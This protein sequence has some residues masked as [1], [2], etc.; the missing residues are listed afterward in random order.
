M[1]FFYTIM[2]LILLTSCNRKEEKIITYINEKST[3]I[4]NTNE[5]ER[6]L[7]EGTL[8]YLIEFQKDVESIENRNYDYYIIADGTLVDTRISQNIAAIILNRLIAM[9]EGDFSAFR[10][11]FDGYDMQDGVGMNQYLHF[12][13]KWFGDILEVSYDP[14]ADYTDEIR[15]KIAYDEFT[16]SKRYMWKTIEKIEVVVRENDPDGKHF[17]ISVDILN[18][19]GELLNYI[20]GN[21]FLPNSLGGTGGFQR[22]RDI[23]SYFGYNDF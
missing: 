2:L 23:N 13:I 19:E 14:Q 7:P 8:Q 16:P 4:Y 18:Y 17:L 11:T 9:E 10:A 12:V 3:E 22:M 1:K 21:M 15:N 5:N 6:V 20:L